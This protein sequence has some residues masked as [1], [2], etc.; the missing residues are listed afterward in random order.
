L[1]TGE[2]DR[3]VFEEM[4]RGGY[5]VLGRT[6]R[7]TGGALRG[8]GNGIFTSDWFA[9]FYFILPVFFLG[10]LFGTLY[11]LYFFLVTRSLELLIITRLFLSWWESF[12]FSFWGERGRAAIIL[13]YILQYCLGLSQE[14]LKMGEYCIWPIYLLIGYLILELSI[15]T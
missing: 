11:L 10:A 4:L 7:N 12:P 13:V 6:G 15:Q 1:P 9:L 2:W 8:E 14:S 3:D 5:S